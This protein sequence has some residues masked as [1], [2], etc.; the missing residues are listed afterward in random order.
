M[1]ILMI[2]LADKTQLSDQSDM[3][4]FAISSSSSCH[5]RDA[6][7]SGVTVTYAASL[8]DVKTNEDDVISTGRK[9]DTRDEHREENRSSTAVPVPVDYR[10]TFDDS[11]I[12][13]YSRQFK[14][15]Q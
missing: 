2:V 10:N 12:E 11:F 8:T 3:I 4:R 5:R 14:C 15:A 6:T 7:V 13:R 1:A 9:T